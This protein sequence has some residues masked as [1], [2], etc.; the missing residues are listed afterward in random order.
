MRARV[1]FLSLVILS[2]LL[3]IDPPAAQAP[4]A[5][6]MA[7]GAAVFQKVCSSCHGDRGAGGRA[8]SLVDN[9]RLRAL[10]RAEI[11]NIIRNGMP[12]GMPPFGS[13]PEA[14][15]QAVTTF[16]RSLN[17][18]A[19]DLE[20]VGDVAA[21]ESFFFGKG[22]CS[23]CHIARGQGAAGGPDLSNIGRQ[24]TVPELTRALAEPNATIATGYATARVQ[25]KDGR[26]LRGFVRNEGN[27]ILPLQ[28]V[29][30]RLVAVDKR[31]AAI[32]R[33]TG[34]AMPPLNATPDETR[35]LIAF[36]GR[37]GGGTGA[38]RCNG[39]NGCDGLSAEARSAKVRQRRERLRGDCEAAAWRLADVS[40]AAR[41]EPS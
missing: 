10:S 29:D 16:V 22:Q 21:G 24:M 9:R 40:R 15:L 14:D 27:H 37:L 28:T 25:L 33:E 5:G 6:Q 38:I 3:S 35:D 2:V 23:S 31:T 4:P 32:T 12:N 30:G 36:L 26:T 11:D 7:E 13:L 8:L 39:C 1:P 41:W 20:P 19:F 17:A 34:S 18:S